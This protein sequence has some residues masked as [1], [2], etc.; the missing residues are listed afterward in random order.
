MTTL[1]FFRQTIAEWKPVCRLMRRTRLG[2]WLILISL[3]AIDAAGFTDGSLLP[4]VI[5][6]AGL[7]A[8]LVAAIVLVGP[9]AG[10]VSAMTLRH[11]ASPLALAAGRWLAVTI[12]AG[13]V[14]LIVAVGTA[15]QAEVEWRVGIEAALS[16]AG[17]TVPVAMCGLLV[18]AGSWRRRAP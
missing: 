10:R 5:L 2:F 1:L 14:I 13:L 11:P 7:T 9:H 12:L 18:T 16:A 6:G 4:M 3:G 17:V 15:W 8:T